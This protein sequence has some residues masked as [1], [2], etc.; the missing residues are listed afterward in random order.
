VTDFAGE[1]TTQAVD[2]VSRR[3]ANLALQIHKEIK[4]IGDAQSF[5]RNNI[6]QMAVNIV[7]SGWN[8]KREKPHDGT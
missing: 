4:S 8:I 5:R 1:Q 6:E 2:A 7:Q 3:V